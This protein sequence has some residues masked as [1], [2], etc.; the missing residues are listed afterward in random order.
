LDISKSESLK[1]PEHRLLIFRKFV[2]FTYLKNSNISKIEISE[3]NDFKFSK[4]SIFV[5]TTDDTK[6][7]KIK[8]KIRKFENEN[9]QNNTVYNGYHDNYTHNPSHCF[10]FGH[11]SAFGQ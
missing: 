3:F 8:F 10:S 7:V 11:G 4:L 2:N 9:S 1:N 5:S 6:N